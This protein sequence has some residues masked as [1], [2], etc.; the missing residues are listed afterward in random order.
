MNN[1]Y[2]PL[3]NEYPLVVWVKFLWG[4]WGCQAGTAWL[5][6]FRPGYLAS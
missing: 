5:L 1:E 6:P 2:P 3:N 4:K